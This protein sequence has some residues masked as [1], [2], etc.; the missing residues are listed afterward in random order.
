MFNTV[1]FVMS[2]AHKIYLDARIATFRGEPVR[3]FAAFDMRNNSILV[4]NLLPFRPSENTSNL[5]Q[6]EI[7]KRIAIQ[8]QTLIVTDSPDSFDHYDIAFHPDTHLDIA[9]NAYITYNRQGVLI[10]NEELRGRA[11][12]E[13]VLD[14]KKLELS[15]GMVYQLDPQST[16]NIHVA[17]LAMCYAAKKATGGVGVLDIMNDQNDKPAYDESVMPFTI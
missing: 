9:A 14:A 8:N 5:T 17:I 7:E 12:V 6:E 2:N 13:N 16:N 4:S 1:G 10:V 11:N 3:I 15:K